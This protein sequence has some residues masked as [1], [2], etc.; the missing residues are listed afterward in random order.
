MPSASGQTR[1]IQS[2]GVQFRVALLE[3]RTSRSAKLSTERH[4]SRQTARTTCTP[5]SGAGPLLTFGLINVHISIF[6]VLNDS[7]ALCDDVFA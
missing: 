2:S 5:R 3:I 7:N 6:E 4:R 1:P